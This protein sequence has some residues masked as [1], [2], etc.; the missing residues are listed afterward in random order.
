MT[1]HDTPHEQ[2]L[3]TNYLMAQR[4]KEVQA[5]WLETLK[6]K[7]VE[8][9]FFAPDG[10]MFSQQ[11]VEDITTLVET[12]RM[13]MERWNCRY[14]VHPYMGRWCLVTAPGRLRYYDTREAA[15]MVAIHRG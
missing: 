11:H 2:R 9:T 15:E 13:T 7:L 8:V 6:V 1:D 10:E 14:A 12:I 5:L 4:P 3:L